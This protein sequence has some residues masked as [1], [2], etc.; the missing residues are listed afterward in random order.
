[1]LD[2]T[3]FAERR[4]SIGT[5]SIA[6]AY[7]ALFGMYFVITQYLQLV[8]GYSPLIAG[9]CALPAGLAQ[10]AVANLAKPLTTR[11]G[12]R[13]VL[14]T[15]LA[16]S[17]AGLLILATTATASQLWTL[18]AGLAL[19]GIGIGLTMPPATGAIMSSLP[20][21]KA[22]VGSAVND[23]SGELGGAFGIGIL[24]SLTID[25]YRSHLAPI[26]AQSHQPPLIAT[27]AKAGL[28]QALTTLGGPHSAP[29]LAA[30]NAYT[31]GLGL[32]MIVGAALVAAA[33]VTVHLALA[34]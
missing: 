2:L 18:E 15:G 11:H 3:F 22:G 20:P 8:R 10:F 17:A 16:A 33:A 32:A 24:G 9:L 27:Q 31:S 12:L 29:G 19:L 28:A 26:L 25:R 30:R 1:M 7:F 5:L 34:N 13:P 23:L 4:L 6:A 21:H 14:T